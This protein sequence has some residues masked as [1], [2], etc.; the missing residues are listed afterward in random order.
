MRFLKQS[1]EE[2]RRV[3]FAELANALETAC[4]IS[5]DKVLFGHTK[6]ILEH[7]LT[8]VF[9]IIGSNAEATQIPG[10]YLESPGTWENIVWFLSKHRNDLAIA[11]IF[12]CARQT[13]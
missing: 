3:H 13:Y 9:E 8:N 2:Q 12:G 6:R 5:R 4:A 1:K 11:K 7:Y 10:T